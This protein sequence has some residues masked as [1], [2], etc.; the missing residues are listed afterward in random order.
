VNIQKAEMRA[1]SLLNMSAH[2]GTSLVLCG[3]HGFLIIS[4]LI[5]F[6]QVN[7]LQLNLAQL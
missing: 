2:I 7:M 4:P 6:S 1:M 5:E 3:A